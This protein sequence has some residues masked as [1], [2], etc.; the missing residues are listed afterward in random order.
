[1]RISFNSFHVNVN[2]FIPSPLGTICFECDNKALRDTAASGAVGHLPVPLLLLPG[3]LHHPGVRAVLR[4]RPR[5]RHAVAEHQSQRS[6]E[7]G[8]RVGGRASV[9]GHWM[10]RLF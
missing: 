2:S 4:L 1:M 5:H 9:G 10:D 8:R 7:G 6:D 3:R